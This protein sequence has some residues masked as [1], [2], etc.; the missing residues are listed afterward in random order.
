M[1][2]GVI[3]AAVGRAAEHAAE[4]A[5]HA[6]EQAQASGAPELPNFV[7]VLYHRFHDVSF[8]QWLHQWENVVF[9]WIVV[10]LMCVIARRASRRAT[11]VP[12]KLQNFVEMFVEA[13]SNLVSGVLGTK[14][15]RQFTPFLGTL[16]IYILLMNLLGLFPLMKSPTSSWNTTVALAICV[17][18]YVQYTGVRRLGIV[19]YLDHMCGQPRDL[20]SIILVPLMLPLHI[21]EELAKPLSLSLRLFGNVTG[22]DVLIAIFVGLGV[23][24]LGFLHLPIGLPLHVPFIFLALLTSTIQALVFTL[25]ST[26]Y[27]SMMLPHEEHGEGHLEC[28]VD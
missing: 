12:G 18:C 2:P 17:F 15:G 1:I 26:V 11:L 21:M 6:A 25:L 24:A 20:V 19:G 9:S 28:H 3:L 22:E 27:F 8:L 16:F 14:Y 5:E 13:L 23:A 10:I 7:T 4:T